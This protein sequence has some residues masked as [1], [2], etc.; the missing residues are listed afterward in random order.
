MSPSANY[1]DI[2]MSFNY[3]QAVYR[4]IQTFGPVLLVM[5]M[6]TV[7]MLKERMNF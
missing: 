2:P 6:D 7:T 3:N 5:G 1:S 4:P